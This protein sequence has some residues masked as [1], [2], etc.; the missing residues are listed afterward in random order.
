[1]M[2]ETGFWDFTPQIQIWT[3]VHKA[4][5]K[6]FLKGEFREGCTES[7]MLAEP[8]SKSKLD[9]LVASEND[10]LWCLV[11]VNSTREQKQNQSDAVLVLKIILKVIGDSFLLEEEETWRLFSEEQL[12]AAE[13]RRELAP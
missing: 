3:K 4:F 1:M 12:E 8:N 5:Q 9:R 7:R 10:L 6:Q 2:A 11:Q 13:K